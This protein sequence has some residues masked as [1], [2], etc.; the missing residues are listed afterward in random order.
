MHEQASVRN[1]AERRII[2]VGNTSP[3]NRSFVQGHVRMP[4]LVPG[5]DGKSLYCNKHDLRTA[6][7]LV[8]FWLLWRACP[9]KRAGGKRDDEARLVASYQPKKGHA[10]TAVINRA[11]SEHV[12]CHSDIRAR[13]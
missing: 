4:M 3:C 2:I 6:L 9:S 11:A 1:P 5:F 10:S 13:C 12:V 7:A 8:A